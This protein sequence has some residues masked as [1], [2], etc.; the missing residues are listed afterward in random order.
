MI[1]LSSAIQ[2]CKLE[3]CSG[4]LSDALLSHHPKGVAWWYCVITWCSEHV[5]E[6][7]PL[8]AA[9]TELSTAVD[10]A[11]EIEASGKKARVVS[12]VCWELF[13]EQDDSYKNSIL[14]PDVTARVSHP[15]AQIM[16]AV[17][18]CRSMIRCS[19]KN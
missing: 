13:E 8:V 18:D 14:P 4:S 2:S 9:G 12:A 1:R 10:A 7:S 5:S 3:G 16:T 6:V 15:P 17:P 11:K 19:I